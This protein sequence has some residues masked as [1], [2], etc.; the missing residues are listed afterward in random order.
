MIRQQRKVAGRKSRPDQRAKHLPRLEQL[1]IREVLDAALRFDFGTAASPVATGYTQVTEAT[2]FSDATGYGWLSGGVQSR[3][4]LVGDALTRDLN[5]SPDATFGVKLANGTYAVSVTI[6]DAATL[7]DEDVYL[8]GKKVE[9][10]LTASAGQFATRTYTVA[11]SDG[12][13]ALRLYGFG[14]R[15]DNA[16]INALVVTPQAQAPK[17]VTARF[18]NG[19]AVKEGSAGSVSFSGVSGGSGAYLYSYDFDN[20]GQFEITNSTSPT[21]V[22]P[23]SFLADGPFTRTV[24]GVVTDSSGAQASY[25]TSIAVNNVAPTPAI[26]IVPTMG[27]AAALFTFA[28]SATDP[29]AADQASLKYAWDFGDGGSA[30][31]ANVSHTYAK[32]GTYAVTLRVTDKDGGS[33]T[34]TT[35]VVYNA[36][37]P[38]APVTATFGNGGAVKEGSA[39]SVSFSGVSGGSGAYLYSYDFDND[40]KFEIA[41]STSPTAVVPAS[42]L[43]DGPGSRAVRGVVTDSGGAQA[44][45]TTSIAISNVAPTPTITSA[46]A[47][48]AANVFSFAGSA[49][50]PSTADQATL[51]Y[52]WDFGDGT[53]ATGASASHTYAKPGTY[54][55]TFA[56]TD[57][58]GGSGT[59]TT[60]VVYNAPP[61]PAPVTA[62]FGNG[63][64]VNEG[65]A[66]SVSFSGVSG[67]SGGYTYSYDFNND[68]TFEITNSTSPTAAVPSSF[69]AD[70]PFTRVVRGV[71]TDSSGNTAA[72]TTSITVNNVAPTPT[73]TYTGSGVVG[74]AFA[75]TGTATDPST[76]DQAAL[77][78]SWDFG[79]GSTATGQNPSHSYAAAGTYTVHLTAADKD[80]GAGVATATVTVSTTTPPPTPGPTMLFDFGTATSA[81]APGAIRVTDTTMYTPDAQYGWSA[82]VIGGSRD[83]GVGIGASEQ[84]VRLAGDDLTR[85]YCFFTDATFTVK[86]PNGTYPVKLWSGDYY[87]SQ[88]DVSIYIQGNLVDTFSA[89]SGHVDVRYFMA[90][91]TNGELSVRLAAGTGNAVLNGLEINGDYV[92][93]NPLTPTHYFDFGTT[94]SPVAAGYTQVSNESFYTSGIGYGWT[95]H[96][97][98]PQPVDRG[99]GT[100]V[101]RDFDYGLTFTFRSDVPNGTYN[102]E[103]TFADPAGTHDF[104]VYLQGALQDSVTVPGGD[105]VVK[106]YT[107]TVTNGYIQLTLNGMEFGTVDMNAILNGL[108]ITPVG[109]PAPAPLAATFGNGGAVREG[110]AGSVSFSGVSG[111]T[112]GYTYS[113]DFN[114]DGTF[115]IANSTSPTAAVPTSF[116]DDG[117]GSRTVRGVVT[118]SNGNTA[119]YTTSI[120]V[121]NAAPTATITSAGAGSSA[122]AFSFA[123]S[124][125]DPSAADQASL[126]YAW[127]FG[128]GATATGASASHT[129]ATAGTYTVTFTAVDKDGGSGAAT[130]TVTVGTPTTPPPSPGPTPS[131]ALRLAFGT[132]TSAVPS[133][134]T[135]VTPATTYSATPG[136]GWLTT[137]DS[138]D[139]GTSDP[140]GASFDFGQDIS[141]QVDLAPGVYDVRLTSGDAGGPH[142]MDVYLNGTLVDTVATAT[143]IYYQKT[144]TVT[145]GTDGHLTLRLDGRSGIDVN[146]VL[147]ALEVAPTGTLP[148]AVVPTPLPPPPGGGGDPTPPPTTTPRPT[149]GYIVTPA[150]YIPD[151][152]ANPTIVSAH[153]GP[154]S[155]PATWSAGRVPGAG[156]VVSIAAGMTV[157]YDVVSTSPVT[158]VVVQAGAHLVFRTDIN[159]KL[160]VTNLLVLEGGELQV[161]S[162]SNPVDPSVTAQIVFNDVP[163]DTTKDPEQFGNGLIGLGKVTMYGAQKSD[164]FVRLA[165]EPR[166][167]DTTLTLSQAVTGW[168]VGDRLVLPDTR[169][170]SSGSLPGEPGFVGQWEMATIAAISA[171]GRTITLSAPLAY[172]HLG[173]RDINGH[174]DF[175]AQVG[176]LTR[177]VQV[178][179]ANLRGTRGHTLFTG[180]ADVDIHYA[181]FSGLGRTTDDRLDSTTFDS[182]W[183]VSH[184]GTN[185]AGRYSVQFKNL[186]GPAGGQADGY[187]YTFQ[188]NSVFCP[189]D[190][191]P[192]RWGI[193]IDASSYG[194]IQDNVLY[195]WA[196]AGIITVRGSEVGNVIAHNDVVRITGAT[197]SLSRPDVRGT[198]ED[199]G[200]EGTG[201]WMRG[202]MNYVRDN[203]VTDTPVAYLYFPSALPE[204]IRVPLGPGKDLTKDGEYKL[205]NPYDQGITEFRGNEA[206]GGST[207][208]GLSIWELGCRGSSTIYTETP[209]SVIK[210]FKVWN[211]WEKGYFN[212]TTYH[213][214]FDGLQARG[215]FDLAR[216]GIGATM[217]YAGDYPLRDFTL[218]NAD[219]QGF[220]AGYQVGSHGTQVVRD[221]YFACY[222]G[223]WDVVRWGAIRPLGSTPREVDVINVR[224]GDMGGRAPGSD[225]MP[226]PGNIIMDGRPNGTETNYIGLDVLRVYSYNG[227]AGDNFQAY[228]MQ[229]TADAILPPTVMQGDYYVRLGSPETGLTN[230]ENWATYG[231]AFAGAI[232]PSTATTRDAIDGLVNPI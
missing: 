60:S 172:D 45:F 99:T 18:G 57:K 29:S 5:F 107:V 79:D 34:A 67:G 26:T 73:V 183:N 9:S 93:P 98:L 80:G 157:S 66:G 15:D 90:T 230:A 1:E 102:V 109:S 116:L 226:N 8:Q 58:D 209:E 47:G 150:G 212:Y 155:D 84:H 86:M 203:V 36:P 77:S 2:K 136:Y 59:A 30:T 171:D 219:V 161:G 118:D 176:N 158:T 180:K 39:G 131:T 166:A 43:D 169:Q 201:I 192:F 92:P 121:N 149:A 189:L 196:G 81:V 222:Y 22:V 185:Q 110:S 46:A 165:G 76:A 35:S 194:L 75:F 195:N 153:S 103:T 178:K 190:P 53:G 215:N 156:D 48:P 49:T 41:N 173:A 145:V 224:F 69:L 213:L 152:S 205:V 105:V 163:I 119:A 177:N 122:N 198:G 56:A 181:Q 94:T 117:P 143:G 127:D 3:D 141:F 154:W 232:A 164:T 12:R 214:T 50:D 229:Q 33:G 68:G 128:D 227:V 140:L 27:P 11:V 14:G 170:L 182:S 20:N 95:S 70:G 16:V 200:H 7:H 72:Y 31:G 162:A 10:N 204:S 217:I 207:Q 17:P 193:A 148:A 62:T 44:S 188:G 71:V 184:V 37:P 83:E 186:V 91:V 142:D 78:Y 126:R 130:T 187:Q 28:G 23:S 210:D 199:I 125:T 55:V 191:M 211:V 129:Y 197:A 120:A 6:G 225:G 4:R 167:G 100:D 202:T 52:S 179:S 21:A 89:T 63:G 220:F 221:S 123:G 139:R 159:T 160:S 88:T 108:V 82:G 115:E 32:P 24:R 175:T 168:R 64:A 74:S 113:Y 65:S 40:G 54:T 218:K 42:F 97:G 138:R 111:G 19:G 38:P 135:K 231:I 104:N 147:N 174:L 25:T 132:G 216:R 223:V 228:Y 137:V 144:Q 134:F 114:N 124:A 13:L 146:A 106:D 112:G 96:R 133:G 208:Q 206:Y 151:F 85:D 51:K 87:S 61:P 101:T